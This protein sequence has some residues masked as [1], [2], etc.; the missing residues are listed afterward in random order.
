MTWIFYIHTHTWFNLPIDASYKILAL[1]D[2]VVSEEK[3]FE[4]DGNTH[5][6]C[7]RLGADERLGVHVFSE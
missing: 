7:N 2:H 3:M 6:Y 1:I 4:C 5:V